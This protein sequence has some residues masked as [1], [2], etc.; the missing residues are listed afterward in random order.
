MNT[1]MTV[2]G[3]VPAS[4]LGIVL[5]HEHLSINTIREYRSDGLVNDLDLAV[6]E[7]TAF[8][9]AG[10]GTIVELTT[11]NLGRDPALL[12][13]AS[14]E[15]GVHIVMGCGYYRDP[16]IVDT[17]ADRMSVLDLTETLVDEIVNGVGPH[18]V[19]PGIIGEVGADAPWISAL[20]ERTLRAAGAAQLQTGLTLSLHAARWQVGERL[21]DVLDDVGVPMA[22]VIIGHLDTVNDRTY[23]LRIAAR[24]CWLEFDGFASRSDYD[25]K[26]Q[27]D[28]IRAIIDAGHDDQILIS[29]D[30]F[31]LSHYAAYGGVGFTFILD[32]V[33]QQLSNAGLSDGDID[34]LV[35]A[36]PQRALVGS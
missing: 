14:E 11:P 7:L 20:E 36:N 35:R 23:H 16:Y 19:R 24:G 13:R 4:D 25:V 6:R 17:G 3:P 12:R 34:K 5:I 32:H 29:H 18:R 9:A 21:L 10:G 26:R 33:C 22:R 31:R 1:V 27:I 30:L 8:R 2:H 15:S 28:G